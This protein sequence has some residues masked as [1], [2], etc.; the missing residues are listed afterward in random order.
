MKVT[1][2]NT[3]I[4]TTYG[5]FDYVPA[6]LEQAKEILKANDVHSAVG[7]KSTADV[8]TTL[9]G[10]EVPINRV[11]YEQQRDEVA[12]VFKLRSRPEEGKILTTEEIEAIGYDF[13]LIFKI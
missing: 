4:L 8:L 11:N 1:I 12:L 9:L 10:I 5:R 13:G 2:L 3:S 7:H 6:T